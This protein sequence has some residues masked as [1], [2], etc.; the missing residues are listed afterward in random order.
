MTPTL[1]SPILD[2]LYS[3]TI[4]LRET[5]DQSPSFSIL[6]INNNNKYFFMAT[7]F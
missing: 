2:S 3:N 6:K 1:K 7:I 4:V 5:L